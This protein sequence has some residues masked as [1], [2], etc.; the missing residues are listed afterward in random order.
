VLLKDATVTA[1][2][3]MDVGADITAESFKATID[4]AQDIPPVKGA[5]KTPSGKWAK[6]KEDGGWQI[7]E[8]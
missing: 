3:S 2:G 1:M 8:N 5:K 4:Q 6:Q 7:W